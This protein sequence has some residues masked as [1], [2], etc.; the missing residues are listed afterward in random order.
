[1]PWLKQRLRDRVAAEQLQ[2]VRGLREKVLHDEACR[3]RLLRS[4]ALDASTMFSPA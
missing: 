3:Q 2:T 4:L 1:M